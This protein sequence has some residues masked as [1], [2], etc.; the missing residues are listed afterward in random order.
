M[1][2]KNFTFHIKNKTE[3]GTHLRN[4]LK[5]LPVSFLRSLNT[6]HKTVSYISRFSKS[7]LFPNLLLF[8]HLEMLTT[9]RINFFDDKMQGFLDN[10]WDVK[11][12]RHTFNSVWKVP[13]RNSDLIKKNFQFLVLSRS[14][15]SVSI[16]KIRLE[17]S[18]DTRI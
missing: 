18:S 12:L 11:V 9:E 16:L 1:Q 6:R 10:K 5:L 14:C 3:E 13:F 8:C 4:Y 17:T 2:Y 15:Q 7:F